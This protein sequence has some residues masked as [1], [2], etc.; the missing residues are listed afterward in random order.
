MQ[1]KAHSDLG[2]DALESGKCKSRFALHDLTN[3]DDSCF[4][5]GHLLWQGLAGFIAEA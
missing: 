3:W 1:H 4:R 2:F 5:I